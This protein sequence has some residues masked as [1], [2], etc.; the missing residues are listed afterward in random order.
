[1][2]TLVRITVF[3]P[4]LDTARHAIRQGFSR[5]RDLDGI[6]SDYRPDSELSRLSTTAAGAAV[7]VSDDVYAVLEASQQLAEQTDGAFDITLGPVVRLWREARRTGVLPDEQ[8]LADARARTGW[9]KLHLD[10]VARTVRLAM[11]GM[12]LD[13]G[14]IGKGYAATEALRAI[15]AAGV[16]SALVAVSGDLAFGAAPPGRRGWRVALSAVPSSDTSIPRV[17]ELTD[18]AVSTSGNTEQHLDVDGTRYSHVVEP[19]SGMGLVDDVTVTVIAPHGLLADGLDTAVSVLGPER[20]MALLERHPAAAGLIVTGSGDAR[21][22]LISPG[23]RALI[24]S[25][26]NQAG[27][28]HR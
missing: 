19:A 4:D 10:P 26:P 22:L 14:A 5:V 8:A 16:R 9:T 11:P 20:G 23:L 25:P 24:D 12:A 13:V 17:L 21:A 6:L 28:D 2:G 3:A 1:M 15:E 18:A 27:P 7:P